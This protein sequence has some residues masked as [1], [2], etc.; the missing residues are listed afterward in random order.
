ML[1]SLYSLWAALN[2]NAEATT[3]A[4]ITV[5]DIIMKIWKKE[6]NRKNQ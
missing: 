5:E 6:T 3:I 1:H 4:Q 2:V